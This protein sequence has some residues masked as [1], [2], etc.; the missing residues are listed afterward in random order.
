MTCALR[1]NVL[2]EGSSVKRF[3]ACNAGVF[4][5]RAN[6]LLAKAHVETRNEGRK[7]GESKGAGYGAEREKRKRLPENI[8][9]MRNTPLLVV[10]DRCSGN[11]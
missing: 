9:K 10:V 3:V 6:V 8:V 5:G 7:W 11:E 1:H 4:F 2:F